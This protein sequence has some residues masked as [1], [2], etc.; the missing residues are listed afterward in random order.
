MYTIGFSD[1]SILHDLS[2]D[3]V[4]SLDKSKILYCRKKYIPINLYGYEISH[5][6]YITLYVFD[7]N[8]HYTSYL[9]NAL[10]LPDLYGYNAVDDDA[11][12]ICQYLNM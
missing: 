3:D 8:V 6:K 5:E 12:D 2:K 9:K 7:A 1:D 4:Y 11:I 10:E